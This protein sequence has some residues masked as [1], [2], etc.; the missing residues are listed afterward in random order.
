MK[1]VSLLALGLAVG[2]SPA[3]ANEDVFKHIANPAEQVLQTVD[4]ANTR[5]SKLDQINAG[6]VKNLQVAW[7]FSTGVLR[8]HEGSPLVIGNM[9]YVHT[10]FPNIV[11]ALD[12]DQGGK[13]VWKYEPKQDPA[14]IPVMCCDTVNRGL[15]YAENAIFLHQADTTLVSLDAKTGKVNWSVKNGDS[16]IGET[17]TATVLPVKDKLIVGI[18]GAEFGRI[19]QAGAAAARALRAMGHVMAR[20]RRAEHLEADDAVAQIGTEAGR[21]GLGDLH[22]DEAGPG[23]PEGRAR[24][25]GLGDRARLLAV[26]EGADLAIP[27]HAVGKAGPTGGFMGAEDRSDQRKQTGRLAEQPG[28]SFREMAAVHGRESGIEVVVDQR[29]REVGRS[30]N[31][32]HAEALQGAFELGLALRV[33]RLHA[34]PRLAQIARGHLLRQAERRPIGIGRPAASR[35]AHDIAALQQPVQRRVDLIEREIGLQGAHDL[36]KPHLG[37]DRVGDGAVERAVQEELPVLGIETQDIWRQRVDGEMRREL[38]DV[39]AVEGIEKRRAIVP[40]PA[41]ACHEVRTRPGTG[42][43]RASARG[44]AMPSLCGNFDWLESSVEPAHRLHVVRPV[45]AGRA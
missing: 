10:P 30:L 33:D 7:T 31:E 25:R 38:R 3:Y 23:R 16:K 42:D 45:S 4:Y 2:L 43:G 18:S 37:G 17:N 24:E 32:T 36:A 41:I 8:G 39:A 6:N 19:V 15:A 44:G 13:I 12:L 21:D 5:Y 34:N 28:L 9:M 22:R 35:V 40:E 26:E 20:G 14:V 11:Y 27:L 29:D 1:S